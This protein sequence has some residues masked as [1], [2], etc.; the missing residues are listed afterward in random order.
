MINTVI[1]FLYFICTK[2]ITK[3]IS[4]KSIQKKIANVQYKDRYKVLGQFMSMFFPSKCLLEFWQKVAR[5]YTINS[6]LYSSFYG[7][8][9]PYRY[10]RAIPCSL[11]EVKIKERERERKR[12]R[13]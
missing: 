10:L 13:E 7:N 11:K 5:F 9:V 2:P 1:E 3:K 12:E 4:S 6:H 8:V